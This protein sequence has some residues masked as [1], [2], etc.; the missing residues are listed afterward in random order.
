MVV[1]EF[2]TDIQSTSANDEPHKPAVLF[3]CGSPR[4]NGMSARIME[5]A[6][7]GAEEAGVEIKRLYLADYSVTP[8]HGCDA[9]METGECCFTGTNGDDFDLIEEYFEEADAA[10][11]FSPLYFAGPPAML[12]CVFDRFQPY[13]VRRYVKKEEM[14]PNRLIHQFV[15]GAGNDP[16]G[17]GPTVAITK[18][19]FNVF[20]F[21]TAAVHNYIGYS[22]VSSDEEREQ[23]EADARAAAYDFAKS[24]LEA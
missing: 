18:S 17:E 2:K 3:I 13:W 16:F 24:L 15:I 11:L 7:A 14:P 22:N 21:R 4:T 10:M 12:K 19:A 1:N 8:C 6:I 20:G 5:C 9:C 23:F